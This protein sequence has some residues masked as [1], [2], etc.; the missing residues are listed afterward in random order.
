MPDTSFSAKFFNGKPI[1]MLYF[2][3]C[4]FFCLSI[5]TNSYAQTK[6]LWQIGKADNSAAEFALAP[7]AFKKF[8]EGFGG[9]NAV[10]YVGYSKPSSHWS[11][12][13]PG[14]LDDW[15]GGGYWSGYHPRHFPRIFFNLKEPPASISTLVLHFANASSIDPP[16]IRVEING[17]KK[18]FSLAAG[19]G[20]Y[21]RDNPKAKKSQEIKINVLAKYFVK[22]LNKIRIGTVKGSWAVFDD[23]Q[24]I[25]DDAGKSGTASNTL[26]LS[27]QAAGY[28]IMK[29][30]V[31]VQPVLIDNIQLDGGQ[32]MT[33]EIEG[34]KSVTRL[35]EKGHSIIEIPVPAIKQGRAVT[36]SEIKIEAANKLVYSGTITRSPQPLQTY[37]DYVDLL[38]GTGNS[39]WMFKPGPSLPLSM[40]QIAP[41]NQDETW[42]A[43]YEYTID[44]IMGFS[45]FSDWTMYGL[46]MMPTGGKLQVDPGTEDNPDG[47]YRS[48]IDKNTEKASIGKYSIFMTDTRIKAEITATRRAALQRYTFPEMDSARIL[49]DLFT[50]NEYPHNLVDARIHTV[51]NT[52]I[53]GQA[54]Y[55]N[56][57]TGYSLQQN[58][59]VYFVLQFSKPFNS[60]GGWTN[61]QVKAVASYIPNWNRNHQFSSRPLIMQNITELRGKGDAG[62]FLNFKTLPGEVINVRSG[63]SL[64]DIAGARNNLQTELAEPFGWDFEKVVQ[65]ARTIWN[66][67]LGRIDIETDDRLQKTKFYTNLYRAISAKAIWSDV[68]GRF[69][70]ENEKIRQLSNTKDCIVSGE[71]W[72][73]FWN[74][75][76]LFN[77]IAPEISSKWAR[78]AI[79]LYK[80]GGW[81]NTDPAGI[82]HTGVMV[83]MH[84]VSQ[85]QGAWQSG[86]RDFSLDTAYYGLRKMLTTPPRKYPGGGTAGVENLVP[87]LKYGY[88]PQGMGEVSNTMEYAF[89]DW[90]LSQ[91]ALTLGKKEDYKY[92]LKRS[93]TWRS[94]LDSV[95]GFI[96]PKDSTGN[97]VVPF[98]PYRTLGFVEG[99]AFNY[100]WFVPHDPE[101]LIAAIG[102]QRFINRLDSAMQKSSVANFNA[103]G[104]DFASYPVNHG[105]EPAMHVAYLFNWAGK[106]WLTQK[107]VRAI[108]EQYYGVTPYDAYPGDEDLGQMSSWFVMSATGLFQMDGGCSQNPV[109]ELGSPRYTKVTIRLKNQY[110][111]GD[112][113]TI[114]ARNASKENKYIHSGK[115]NGKIITDFKISQQDVLKG[116]K[117]ELIMSP[118]PKKN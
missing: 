58:Y 2:K 43:G 41:D 48:R 89:D 10:Y 115:L 88:V 4:L 110:G 23:L 103:S 25:T 20:K 82:E 26:I 95:S 5:F 101:K 74:N 9:E 92:F 75:Q 37:A 107:W 53:E 29:D 28:E 30:G 98:D 77:L 62:V 39:R 15:A 19:T 55:Y 71:Y 99:N 11:F 24:F 66:D 56:A 27:A 60:M 51:S 78:S 21:P 35:F 38:M 83:A 49:V 76:Q 114:E 46:L 85:I 113:F 63:V 64:V 18:E 108:Q 91:M 32:K 79:E 81:F 90:C 47:G 8:V 68:D 50:P 72:N 13:L 70:D 104:D 3:A 87:Y 42:K 97:W 109:Y 65:N 96:R 31:K 93:A 52:E 33:I 22:G 59:T 1:F 45:H 118:V 100:N 6:L 80:N 44:N 57:F 69:T 40:V 86:I 17:F 14:P 116:G 12:V 84:V 36:K 102:K 16:V 105:N 106:P 73:T 61:D 112:N 34:Q 67:Y 54:T 7:E 117:L 94:L 111:R